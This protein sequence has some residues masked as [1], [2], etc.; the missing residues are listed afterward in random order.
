MSE[1]EREWERDRERERKSE[2]ES[3]SV[4]ECVSMREREWGTEKINEVCE[5][6]R[7]IK[8]VYM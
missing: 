5:S 6:V 1:R 8:T 3:M 2:R 7:E 4:G